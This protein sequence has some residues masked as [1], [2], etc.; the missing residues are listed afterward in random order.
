MEICFILDK[1]ARA[2][3]VGAVA[4][5]MHTM[6]FSDLRLVASD[7]HQQEEASWVAHGSTH[8]LEQARVF[9][10]IDAATHDCDLLVVTTARRRGEVRTLFSPDALCEQLQQ[11]T[12]SVSRV[13]I[14]FG[15]EAAGL[16][17]EALKQADLLSYVPLATEFPSLNLAQA[18]MVYSYA[19]APLVGVQAHHDVV[20]PQTGAYLALK[21]RFD[22][23]LG[24]SNG[25]ADA[26]LQT[27]L[28]D[29]LGC[30]TDRDVAMC[31]TL[32][33]DLA[34]PK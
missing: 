29:K 14:L 9:S 19:C 32:L 33:N 28:Q 5:A 4:R 17:N 8:I 11:R 26:K 18:C 1:P 25:A 3:N 2:A 22:A 24:S 13:A 16:S 6:G 30:F 31:H 34:K 7:V 23:L 12:Q 27:W 10:S 20:E 21:Q 15:C